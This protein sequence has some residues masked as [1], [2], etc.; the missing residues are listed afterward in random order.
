MN[1]KT[2]NRK[3]NKKLLLLIGVILV[4]FLYWN[5]TGF[6]N[7]DKVV[8]GVTQ[9]TAQNQNPDIA[10]LTQEKV[11]VAYLKKYHRLPEYYITKEEAKAGGWIPSQGN[12]CEVLPGKAIGGDHFGNREK[13][14]P[15]K[16]GRKY[17]EADINYNC[18]RRNADRIIYSSDHLIFITNDHYRT[19]QE[20]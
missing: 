13:R 6:F 5:L 17:F 4:A 10:D 19:F 3:S 8:N 14:L 18:G 1:K 7:Q 16:R 15:I 11:V 12:L 2:P 9:F 20:Q